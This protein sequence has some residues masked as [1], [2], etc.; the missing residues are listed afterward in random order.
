MPVALLA[1]L[2]ASIVAGVRD[3]YVSDSEVV[4][5]VCLDG[6]DSCEQDTPAGT[7]RIEDVDLASAAITGGIAA[8][9]A[10]L[11]TIAISAGLAQSRLRA[12]PRTPAAQ[13]DPND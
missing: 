13:D 12:A 10:A 7:Y 4:V 6:T 3:A 5:D 11:A 8:V 1:F 2:V 9:I